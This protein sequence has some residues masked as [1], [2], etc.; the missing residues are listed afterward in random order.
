MTSEVAQEQVSGKARYS[1]SGG[2]ETEDVI[3]C[4]MANAFMSTGDMYKAWDVGNALKYLLRFGRKDGCDVE[5]GKAEN[6][7]HH[8]RTG[9]WLE[10]E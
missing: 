10:W 7:I 1:L 4:V 5:L 2:V 3:A 6:Y 9:E 8:A